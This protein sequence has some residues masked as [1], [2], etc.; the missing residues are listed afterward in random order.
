MSNKT[1]SKLIVTCLLAVMLVFFVSSCNTV[2]DTGV[3]SHPW[4]VVG[5]DAE[6][7]GTTNGHVDSW[8]YENW[9]SN[10]FVVFP[11]GLESFDQ[12]AE[13][14]GFIGMLQMYLANEYPC[15]MFSDFGVYPLNVF[16]IDTYH[17]GGAGIFGPNFYSALNELK[18]DPNILYLDQISCTKS[19]CRDRLGTYKKIGEKK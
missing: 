4:I 10:K 12:I 5:F 8:T 18:K 6:S 11:I 7:I 9:G 15:W 19:H 14:H 16:L 13:D 2:Y 3:C 17:G 1:K